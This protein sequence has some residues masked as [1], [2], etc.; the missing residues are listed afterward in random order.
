[1]LKITVPKGKKLPG[2]GQS[3]LEIVSS[4]SKIFC[5]LTCMSNQPHPINSKDMTK[6]KIL[7]SLAS[8]ILITAAYAIGKRNGKYVTPS[9]LF[10]TCSGIC[11]RVA[12]SVVIVS[13]R[14]TTFNTGIAPSCYLYTNFN[15]GI[16]RLFA[17]TSQGNCIKPIFCDLCP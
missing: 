12:S 10:Y 6:T 4:I 1:M 5:L 8:L 11:K 17:A 7:L 16:Y 15:A 3:R 9:K 2:A 13:N 14:M